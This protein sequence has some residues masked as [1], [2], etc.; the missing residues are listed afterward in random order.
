M[1]K[2][3]FFVF[4]LFYGCSSENI[5]YR[6]QSQ[7]LPEHIKSIGAVPFKNTS[8]IFSIEDKFILKLTDE[9]IRSGRYKV[10]NPS[11][12]DGVL[13]GE[14]KNYILVPIQYDANMVPTVYKI[15]IYYSIRMIDRKN[16]VVL[17]EEKNLVANQIY[18]DA[19][20]PGGLTEEQA[21]EK[22]WEI[23]SKD[24]VKRIVEGFGSVTG[25]SEKK[26]Q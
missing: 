11:D 26:V 8:T 24:I 12:A 22:L 14:I 18:S 7:L 16:N 3:I 2:L 25:V 9:L 4:F 5:I 20:I 6:P 23:M 10:T 21:R 15:T 19:S 17:W 13:E 1:K